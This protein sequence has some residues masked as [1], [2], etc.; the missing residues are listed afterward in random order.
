MNRRRF[1]GVLSVLGAACTLPAPLLAAESRLPKGMVTFVFDDGIVTNYTYSLPILKRRG[2]IATAGIVVTRML[3]GNNDYMNLE[4]VRELEQSG[5]EIA[6][7]SMTH[8]R[9]IQI[10]KTYEQEIITGWRVDEKHPEHYQAMYDYERI[11]SL[12]QDGKPLYP[13]ESLSQVDATKGSYWLDQAIAE[14]HVHPY[15]CGDPSTLGI[16]AGCYQRE[17][18]DSKRILTELGFKVDTYIAPHNYWSDD[19]EI[20]SKRYYSR[21]CTGR[22]SDNRPGS[23]DPFA[24]KRFMT[25]E[26]DSPQ[27]LIRIMKD[28]CLEHGGW[29]VFC[30]HGVGDKLGW[31]PFPAESLDAVSAW[32]EEQKIPLVTVRDGATRMAELKKTLPA[33]QLKTIVK[34]GF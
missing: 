17:M 33:S 14:L 11:A 10:P 6:S 18:E 28:H 32:V 29:V 3:S 26:H 25:H 34:K 8:S 1:L 20:I 7:H 30:F 12:F 21:A 13:V 19:V 9:P 4:Q 5:W 27:H 23:F 2:Q 15:R 31:E 22:D 16:R 24:I